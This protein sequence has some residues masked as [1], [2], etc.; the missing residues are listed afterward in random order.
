MDK[1]EHCKRCQCPW[2]D[3]GAGFVPDSTATT[4]LGAVSSRDASGDA[5]VRVLFICQ[6]PGDVEQTQATPLVGV[7]GQMFRGRFVGKHLPGVPVG[8]AN[9]LKCRGRDAAGRHTNVM[10]QLNS[11]LW[12]ELK[13]CCRPYLDETI[14]RCPNAILVPMG[15]YAAEA[16]T[17]LKAKAM[18]HLR[19]TL[20]AVP[21]VTLRKP[22]GY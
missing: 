5:A 18:L 16:V 7:T 11:K 20:C 9:V 8:Y 15:E 4:V 19:G 21:D 1:P 13:T 14:A 12:Q 10:P 2:F 6:N 22:S 17:G 3:D